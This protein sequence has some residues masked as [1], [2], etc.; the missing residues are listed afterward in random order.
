MAGRL[1][2]VKVQRE[3]RPG[4]YADGDGP[5][6]IVA[7]ATSKSWSYRYWKGGKQRWLG[8]GS[9]KDVSLRDARLA[10]DAARLRIRGD[11]NTPGIDIVQEKRTA[12][13]EKKA[14]T[15]SDGMG[16]AWA[17]IM[18]QIS[19]KGPSALAPKADITEHHCN[20]F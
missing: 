18:P 9:F 5:Y 8:L 4:K 13:E 11:R 15:L 17:S 1:K 20:V 6:L 3:E 19:S 10:R 12:R 7:S 2:P 16:T 14:S